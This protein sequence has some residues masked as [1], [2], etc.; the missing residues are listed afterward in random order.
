[1]VKDKRENDSFKEYIFNKIYDKFYSIDECVTDITEFRTLFL[2]KLFDF[3][4]SK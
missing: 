2:K 4:K 1:M 3:A